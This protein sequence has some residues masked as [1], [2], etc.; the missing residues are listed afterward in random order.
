MTGQQSS[1]I[2]KAPVRAEVQ[3]SRSRRVY[4]LT[5]V[6]FVLF[7]A[8]ILAT[9][10]V[11]FI[12]VSAQ[13]NL[14]FQQKRLDEEFAAFDDAGLAEVRE[15]N[16]RLVEAQRLLERH[17]SP[18]SIMA[19]LELVTVQSITIDA[20]SFTKIE[21]GDG[22]LLEVSARA[23]Q[24]NA[25]RYQRDLL[26]STAILSGADVVNTTY[27]VV[28]DEE[29]GNS[30]SILTEKDEISFTITK[31]LSV[32]DI[33]HTANPTTQLPSTSLSSDA[34][35]GDQTTTSAD[36]NS[37]SE[38]LGEALDDEQQGADSTNEVIE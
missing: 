32:D 16:A 38:L 12:D 28:N 9:A 13:K 5:Y 11:F 23:P 20:L 2:P 37:D 1:F 33:P 22:Y 6:S 31:I 29:N 8:S 35:A 24:F 3:S 27:G 14:D 21:E 19:A 15:L 34:V 4:I 7:F 30:K 18:V 17:V 10:I 25:T 26:D 36:E